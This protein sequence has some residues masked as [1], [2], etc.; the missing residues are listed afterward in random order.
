MASLL[1]TV[2]NKVSTTTSSDV[3]SGLYKAYIGVVAA[4]MVI[5]AFK[6]AVKWAEWYSNRKYRKIKLKTL[7]SVVNVSS[8]V[9]QLAFDVTVS[10]VAS[11]LVGATAPISV[12]LIRYYFDDESEK[13]KK[14]KELAN[15]SFATVE[16]K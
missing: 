11:G 14:D 7:E 8:D 15:N 10:A 1:N 16:F 3:T 5:G 2:T 6:G 4:S 12:P 9:G 13:Q